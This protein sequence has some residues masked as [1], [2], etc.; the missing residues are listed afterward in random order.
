MAH[1]LAHTNFEL[2]EDYFKS[3][4]VRRPRSDAV[5]VMQG[6]KRFGK[7]FEELTFIIGAR[8]NGAAIDPYELKN[9]SLELSTTRPT[10]GVNLH[11]GWP[12]R[13]LMN[14]RRCLTWVVR[15]AC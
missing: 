12:A 11:R 1:G 9:S 5:Y 4:G 7:L 15:M 10:C 14:P 8:A 2:V 6:R 13:T 3:I